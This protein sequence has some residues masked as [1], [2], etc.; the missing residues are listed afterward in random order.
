MPSREF[1]RISDI[2]GV[3]PVDT[4]GRPILQSRRQMS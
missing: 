4:Y 2:R 1:I 3:F